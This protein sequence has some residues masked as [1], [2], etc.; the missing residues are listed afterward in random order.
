MRADRTDELSVAEANQESG[1]T[2]DELLIMNSLIKAWDDFVCLPHMNSED[3]D[4]FRAAIHQCQLLI[5]QR[6]VR[7]EH[8]VYWT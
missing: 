4:S 2:E 8:P 3:R 1:L 5:A 7:R 6:I